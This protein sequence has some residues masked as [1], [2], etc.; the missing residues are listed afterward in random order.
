L[1]P[2]RPTPSGPERLATPAGSL[3]FYHSDAVG[4]G[5]F[6]SNG[7]GGK[8]DLCLEVDDALLS[9]FEGW[10]KQEGTGL[11]TVREYLSYLRKALGLKLCGKEDVGKYFRAAGMSKRAYEAFR[12][13]LTYVDRNL[14][15][16][17]ELVIKLRKA[18]PRKPRSGAD[19]YVPPDDEVLKLRDHVIKLGPLLVSTGCRLSEA[20]ALVR[21]FSR[22]KLVKV[23]EGLFRYHMDSLRGSKN[24][25]VMYLPAEVVKQV[26]AL[27][28]THIPNYYN[29][30]KAFEEVL[31]PKYVRKWFRQTLKKLGVDPEVIEFIQGRI[32]ALGVGA[33]HYTDFIPL[34]DE[35]YREKYCR[36]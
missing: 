10:L 20:V 22:E 6:S 18:M 31:P 7:I 21:G 33:K 36:R 26:E 12:R 8:S 25:L 14:E 29:I 5:G 19:T 23:G 17:E 24:V 15:G 9:G 1:N 13:L 16:F 3:G 2:R 27:K 34:T 35:T 11:R 4:D 28:G 32:S 30:A